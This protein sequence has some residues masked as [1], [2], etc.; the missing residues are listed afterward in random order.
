MDFTRIVTVVSLILPSI[1]AATEPVDQTVMFK[2]ID[3]LLRRCPCVPINTCYSQG[4]SLNEQNFLN[5]NFQCQDKTYNHCCGP[6]FQTLGNDDFYFDE[7]GF[8]RHGPWRKAPTT[9]ASNVMIVMPPDSTTRSP[10]SLTKVVLV[11]PETTTKPT[12]TTE[13]IE[14]TTVEL[15]TLEP[16]TDVVDTT[17]VD[18]ATTELLEATTTSTTEPSTTTTTTPKTTLSPQ[19]QRIG[20]LQNRPGY[21]SQELLRNRSTRPPKTT[22][23][24]TST[25]T[26]TEAP[27]TRGYPSRYLYRP[28]LRRRQAMNRLRLFIKTSTTPSSVEDSGED[29]DDDEDNDDGSMEAND[30]EEGDGDEL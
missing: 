1:Q 11:Y 28:D 8:D 17:S 24:T 5:T 9:M 13:A 19:E 26:T 22:S 12:T 6:Y 3:S 4:V 29:Y 23:S 20:R 27:T 21:P 30:A 14:E 2:E 16:I 25:T 18:E 10:E 15:T 7:D